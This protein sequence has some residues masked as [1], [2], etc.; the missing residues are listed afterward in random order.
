MIDVMGKVCAIQGNE[1]KSTQV[2]GGKSSRKRIL[3][4][5]ITG[6]RFSL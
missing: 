5:H 1:D 2:Y 3:A 4:C 6:K